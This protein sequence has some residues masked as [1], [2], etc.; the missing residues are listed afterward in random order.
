MRK[1]MLNSTKPLT[2]LKCENN[3]WAQKRKTK[4]SKN[5]VK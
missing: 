3:T 4:N 1:E 5:D 2:T